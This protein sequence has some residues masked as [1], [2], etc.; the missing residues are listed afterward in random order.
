M[1]RSKAATSSSLKALSSDSIGTACTHLAEGGAG[2]AADALRG[3]VGGDELGMRGLERPAAPASAGRTRRPGPAGRRARSSGSRAARSASRSSACAQPPR[4][5]RSRRGARALRRR[6]TAS[7]HAAC[8]R[9]SGLA[10]ARPAARR[11]GAA[12]DLRAVSAAHRRPAGAGIGPGSTVNSFSPLKRCR[13]DRLGDRRCPACVRLA[14]L[15]SARRPSSPA[16]GRSRT[17]RA[18]SLR[19]QRQAHRAPGEALA[20][21]P[22]GAAPRRWRS[23]SGGQ[24]TT[25]GGSAAAAPAAPRRRQG[26]RGCRRATR[27]R[28]GSRP[29]PART[30]RSPRPR[31]GRPRAAARLVVVRQRAGP[32]SAGAAAAASPGRSADFHHRQ[33][34]RRQRAHA[35]RISG[36]GEHGLVP[37]PARRRSRAAV[38]RSSLPRAWRGR[39]S[40]HQARPT[41]NISPTTSSVQRSCGIRP[42]CRRL[43]PPRGARPRRRR[44]PPAARRP[45]RSW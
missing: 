45:A 36:S 8:G 37:M 6:C 22:P 32:R 5:A 21:A 9:V 24:S 17:A 29:R 44:P 16:C 12:R 28:G 2:G 3:R 27:G 11:A 40:S 1:R 35:R 30:R 33:P 43:R 25:T 39:R 10:R 4:R 38:A 31:P 7:A 26:R 13:V 23:S 42:V 41:R 14:A 20:S 15:S 19:R 34:V 18:R